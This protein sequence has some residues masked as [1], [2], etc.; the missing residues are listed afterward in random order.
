[1]SNASLVALRVRVIAPENLLIALI[2]TASGQQLEI[3]REMACY[4]S[5]KARLYPPST[6]EHH[7]AAHMINLI[8]RSC[9]MTPNPG[10]T[11]DLQRSGHMAETTFTV[12]APQS[13]PVR[14]AFST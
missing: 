10:D 2:A 11:I 5:P 1:M 6:D 12:R 14:C 4:I 13:N 7:A 8:G 9:P 3:P